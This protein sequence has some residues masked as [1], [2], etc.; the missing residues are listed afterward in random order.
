MRLLLVEDDAALAE[1]LRSGLEQAGYAVDWSEQAQDADWL[2]RQ[3]LYEAVILDLGLPDR[4]GLE[5]LKDWRQRKL[6]LPVLILTARGA[7]FEKVEGFKAGADDYLAKPFHSEELL[8]RLQALIRRHHRLPQGQLQ[9]GDLVLDENRQEVWQAGSPVV[10]TGQEFRLLRVLMLHPGQVLSKQQLGEQLY[11]FDQEV[12][13]NTLEV[14]IAR[15]R[16]KIGRERIQTR[17]GQG[18]R[19]D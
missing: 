18:Y 15:L 1:A 16:Q 17:R 12:D 3:N 7:W 9:V 10:L 14:F 19:F 11:D 5:L 6:D 13:S 2:V 4:P 8:V